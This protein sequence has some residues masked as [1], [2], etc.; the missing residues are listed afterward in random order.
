MR[1]LRDALSLRRR[2]KMRQIL[3]RLR[4]SEEIEGDL[5]QRMI[6]FTEWQGIPLSRTVCGP[7]AD[8][9]IWLPN[10]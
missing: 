8:G 6:F 4:S 3:R 2:Q 9:I 7:K 5:F 10:G 1:I